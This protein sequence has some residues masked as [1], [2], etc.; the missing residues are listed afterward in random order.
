MYENAASHFYYARRFDEAL[1]YTQRALELNSDYSHAHWMAGQ[2]YV[3]MGLYEEAIAAFANGDAAL[4]APLLGH[5]Y[6]QAGRRVE[7]QQILQELEKQQNRDHVS[8]G[9]LALIHLGLGEHEEALRYLEAAL[10]ESSV[11]SV[12]GT[13]VPAYLKVDPIWDPIRSDPRFAALLEKIG[14]GK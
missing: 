10:D 5:A 2:I 7:A 8:A 12:T 9:D 6:G 3:Q 4:V 14:L 1:E 11:S 13:R